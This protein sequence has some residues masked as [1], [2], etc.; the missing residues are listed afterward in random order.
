[1]KLN[2]SIF[3]AILSILLLVAGCSTPVEQPTA[4]AQPSAQVE[5]P[6]EQPTAPVEQP[7]T[8]AETPVTEEKPVT[9]AKPVEG[10]TVVLVPKGEYVTFENSNIEVAVGSKLT[11]LY[12][13]GIRGK[14]RIAITDEAGKN[15]PPMYDSVTQKTTYWASGYLTPAIK[16]W[17]SPA[18]NT[19]GVYKMKIMFGMQEVGTITVK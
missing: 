1:M 13:E 2:L 9:E 5:Q 15:L 14:T 16:Q 11:F 19:A 12:P 17:T 10:N 3:L 8:P 18:F 7:K 4:P 6:V